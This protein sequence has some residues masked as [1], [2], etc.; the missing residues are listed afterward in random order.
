MIL[1]CGIASEPPL[2]LA[3]EAA[4]RLGLEHAL[5]H[6]READSSCLRLECRGGR[7]GGHIRL[8]GR[9]YPLDAF[10]GVYTRIMDYEGLPENQTST[11]DHSPRIARSAHFHQALN[12]WLEL[13]D[14]RVVNRASDMASNA[15]KPYQAQLIAPFFAV[16]PT[17]VSNDPGDV[18]EFARRHGRVIY[19]SISSVRSIVRELQPCDSARLARIRALPTQFQAFTPGTN[20]RVHV[21]GESVFASEIASDAVDYRYAQRDGM[22]TEMRPLDLPAEVCARCRALSSRLR[23]PFCG[24]DLKRTPQGEYYCFEVNPSPAYSYYQEQT[25]QAISDALVR[26]LA[27]GDAVSG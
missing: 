12:E 25:G 23:L 11:S 10:S 24:I 1:F 4:G 17:L 8:R 13:S 21:V 5:L 18:A 26:Y 22:R 27:A 19:K 2:A 7:L 20:V 9:D 3:I 6:Q 14:C 16:P 15:S